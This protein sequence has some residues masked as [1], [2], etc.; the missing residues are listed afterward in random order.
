MFK[1]ETREESR[2]KVTGYRMVLLIKSS[3]LWFSSKRATS[4]Q[5]IETFIWSILGLYFLTELCDKYQ[6]RGK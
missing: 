1:L 3:Q 4:V 5:L 6:L 2:N